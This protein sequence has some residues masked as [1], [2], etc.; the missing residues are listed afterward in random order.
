MPLLR[1]ENQGIRKFQAWINKNSHQILFT[2]GIALIAVSAFLVALIFYPVAKEEIKYLVS[3]K[4][5][6]WKVESQKDYSAESNN[7]LKSKAIVSVDEEFGIVI[8]KILANAKVIAEV[9]SQN[10]D[11]Y[12]KVLT[13]GV[14]HA[15]GSSLPD[16]SGNTFIFAHSSADILEANKYNAVFYLLSKLEAGDDIYLFY[17]GQ[18]YSYQVTDKK[19]VSAEEVNYL[20]NNAEKQLT[21]MTCWPPGTTL[22]RLIIIAKVVD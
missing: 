12:Q 7:N 13:R 10:S 5:S 11:I 2:A 21:L 18:K 17:K 4:K 16:E 9:D 19:T 6:D 1:E 20:N 3:S 8:P 14:A 15:A 22:K